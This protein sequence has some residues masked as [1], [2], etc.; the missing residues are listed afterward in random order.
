MDYSKIQLI[1][2]VGR[3]VKEFKRQD[4][5]MFYKFTIAV[6]S[7]NKTSSWKKCTIHKGG[8]RQANKA[9]YIVKGFRLFD[10]VLYKGEECFIFGRRS[11]GYFDLR[12]LDG[13][14]VSK[15]ASYKQ[16]KLIKM[17][18]ILLIERR[19]KPLLS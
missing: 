15:S 19:C 14:I 9:P 11:S 17:A 10:K 2:N 18:N 12:K 4:G 8:K 5:K 7:K 3:E 16:I 13:T 1:G 6:G